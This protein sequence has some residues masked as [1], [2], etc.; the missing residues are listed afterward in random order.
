[1]RGHVILNHGYQA[2]VSGGSGPGGGD[3]LYRAWVLSDDMFP[4]E[5]DVTV[6]LIGYKDGA[7]GFIAKLYWSTDNQALGYNPVSGTVAATFPTVSSGVGE[8]EIST[9]LARPGGTKFLKLGAS[10]TSATPIGLW[11]NYTVVLR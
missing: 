9:T 8:F 3:A 10:P 11:W 6:D 2:L 5:G 1:M 4:G 7:G